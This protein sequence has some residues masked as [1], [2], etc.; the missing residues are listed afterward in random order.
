RV[1]EVVVSDFLL[2]GEHQLQKTPEARNVPLAVADIVDPTA[3]YCALLSAKSLVKCPVRGYHAK[4]CVENEERRPRSLDDGLGE[5]PCAFARRSGALLR[6]HILERQTDAVYRA[7]IRP[8]RQR[9]PDEPSIIVRRHL[10]VHRFG[11]LEG[12]L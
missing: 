7:F 3:F 10:R 12:T 5:E 9:L 11:G 1:L 8:V 6:G 4:L 2:S